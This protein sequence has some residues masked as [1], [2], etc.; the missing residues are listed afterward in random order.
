ME[1]PSQAVY[2]NTDGVG[3]SWQIDGSIVDTWIDVS[4]PD[5]V[6]RACKSDIPPECSTVDKENMV[7]T[8]VGAAF[9]AT[10][11][12]VSILLSPGASTPVV[13]RAAP[14]SKAALSKANASDGIGLNRSYL[15]GGGH[16]RQAADS[17]SVV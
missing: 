16:P 15:G 6:H 12:M 2:D 13:A 8:T 4:Y 17:G 3:K 14:W 7:A 11:G 10:C 5:G 9:A 1:E